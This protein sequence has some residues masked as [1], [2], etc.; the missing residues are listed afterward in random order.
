MKQISD[1][2]GPIQIVAAEVIERMS[3]ADFN[4]LMHE[5]RHAT[6]Q[7]WME[8]SLLGTV[9]NHEIWVECP[10]CGFEY[11]RKAYQCCPE[12]VEEMHN[13]LCMGGAFHP[14]GKDNE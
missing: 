6:A 4:E 3:P 7:T 5:V 11:D 2:Q 9:N 13:V 14:T 1:E 8:R 12:C 10:L